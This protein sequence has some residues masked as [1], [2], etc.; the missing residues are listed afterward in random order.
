MNSTEDNNNYT[1]FFSIGGDDYL[2]DAVRGTL[3]VNNG[4]TSEANVTKTLQSNKSTDAMS[5]DF[6]A[7]LKTQIQQEVRK[8]LGDELKNEVNKQMAVVKNGAAKNNTTKI[9]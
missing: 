9:L 5:D 1:F 2:S 4:N 8:L 7:A 3:K 6:K